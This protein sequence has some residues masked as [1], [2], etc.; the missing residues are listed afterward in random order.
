[1]QMVFNVVASNR[2]DHTKNFSFLM[3]EKGQW[4]FSPAYDLTFPF[5]PYQSFGIPHKI[6]INNKVKGINRED[7]VVTAKKVGILNYNEIIDNIVDC[8]STF[9]KR[10]KEYDLNQK[11]VQL[12]MADI[13]K[14]INRV[15]SSSDNSYEIY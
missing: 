15:K 3:D 6:S 14:N 11:T 7:L 8:V 1:M 9:S 2:D 12:V 10:I 4:S 13:E 5:D